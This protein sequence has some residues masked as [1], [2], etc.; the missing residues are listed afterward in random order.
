MGF[1][2]IVSIIK[3]LVLLLY[4]P[5]ICLPEL[6]CAA[7][8]GIRFNRQASLVGE[9]YVVKCAVPSALSSIAHGFGVWVN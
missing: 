4:A 3:P 8:T 7:Q 9:A 1:C 5:L 2:Y 6:R